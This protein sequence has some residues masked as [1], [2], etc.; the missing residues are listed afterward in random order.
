MSLPH[1]AAGDVIDVRPLGSRLKD[2]V[3][4]A[5]FKTDELEVMRLV[6]L[7]G[8]TVPEHQV[9]DDLTIQC[10]EGEIE[11]RTRQKTQ[12]LRAGEMLYLTG[13]EPYSLR[14]A[15]DTSILMTICLKHEKEEPG[16]LF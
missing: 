1:A 5:L 11:V 7:A 14:A 16:S 10:V 4:T 15:T 6:L 8:K 12:L 3:S 9:A 13:C 2:A